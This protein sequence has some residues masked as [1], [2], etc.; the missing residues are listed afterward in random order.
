MSQDVQPAVRNVLRRR[1]GVFAPR[2]RVR[3]T[4]GWL[5]LSSFCGAP[6]LAQSNPNALPSLAPPYG[7]MGPTFWEQH[8]N[9]MLV[10]IFA[11]IAVVGAI[12]WIVLRP[13]VPVVVPPE[14]SARESLGRLARQPE[15]GNVLSEISQTLRRY[16]VAAFG[17][18]G[19]Q[20]TTKEFSEALAGSEKVGPDLARTV[21]TF[22][23]ECDERKFSPAHPGTPLQAADR[24]LEI[25][26]EMERQRAK[27]AVQKSTDERRI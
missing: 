20:S 23:R 12:L 4:G 18:P 14:V 9:G 27:F 8:G 11:S 17:L 10:I 24:A 16:A 21:S 13:K 15:T 6:L 25:I 26:L 2:C 1:A 5:L 3:V 7:E 19:G 22:M